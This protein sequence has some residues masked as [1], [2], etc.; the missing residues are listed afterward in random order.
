MNSATDIDNSLSIIFNWLSENEIGTTTDKRKSISEDLL[1]PIVKSGIKESDITIINQTF[2][3]RPLEPVEGNIW[4]LLQVHFGGNQYSLFMQ[5]IADLTP[6]G[7]NT[8]PNACCGK[9]ELLVRVL[10]PESRQ[11]KKGDILYNGKI[12]EI[13]GSEVRIQD[14]TLTGKAYKK[15][16]DD[17]F[18]GGPIRG[19]TIRTGG[20]AGTEA[21]EIEKSQHREHYKPQFDADIPAA[22]LLIKQYL[23]MIN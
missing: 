22:K 13:K 23:D 19:N 2:K 7:L 9:W 15:N 6:V 4:E 10:L 18:G 5:K 3:V 20:L 11:P 14:Q 8:S 16:C 12:Y 1:L 17:V 21:Y